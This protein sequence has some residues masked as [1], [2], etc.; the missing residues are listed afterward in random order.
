MPFKKLT[1][2]IAPS[3]PATRRYADDSGPFFR[4]EIGF[5]PNWFYQNLGIHFDEKWHT[6][7]LYRLKTQQLMRQELQKR[8]PN[9]LIGNPTLPLDL[10]TGTFGACTVGAIYGL[11]VIYSKNNWPIC[12]Q[13]YFSDQQI[14]NLLPPNLDQNEFFQKLLG[15]VKEI[16]K[17]QGTVQ[18]FINWQGV[19]NNAHRIR[20]EALFIDLIDS[21]SRANHLFNC[22]TTTMIDAAKRLHLV[23]KESGVNISFFTVSN[24][25]VNMLSP[26]QYKDFLLPFDIKIAREFESIGIH[27][28][29]WTADPYLDFY[30]QVPNVSY[31]D[32]GILSDLP[33]AKSLFP[34]ARRAIMYTPMDFV[35]KSLADIKKDLEHIAKNYAPCD[36]VLADIEAG[37]SEKKVLQFLKMCEQKGIDYSK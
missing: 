29:A 9:T 17:L 27:N 7:P 37:T 30:A 28:C 11:P 3:A 15:Q 4:P 31:I 21:P 25:L 12:A 5:T 24:C 32:M 33:K 13:N 10:L 2:Y 36:I 16:E 18:G 1:S 34:N 8:F 19:L 26:R 22:I 23:Q 20:G 14:D 35:E 6:S